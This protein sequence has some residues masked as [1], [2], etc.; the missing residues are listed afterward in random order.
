VLVDLLG[1]AVLLE[2]AAQHARSPDPQDLGGQP[3]LA[4]P[5]AL[6]CVRACVHACMHEVGWVVRAR[7]AEAG[8]VETWGLGLPNATGVQALPHL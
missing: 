8:V 6:A 3:R 7:E 1:V 5:V 2:Q 4:R